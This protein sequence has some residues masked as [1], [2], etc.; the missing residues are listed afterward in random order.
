MNNCSIFSCVKGYI[1]CM[2][3]VIRLFFNDVA[4]VPTAD[5]KL[6]NAIMAI[7]FFNICHKIGKLPISTIGLGFKVRFF[8]NSCPKPSS[9]YDCLHSRILMF[10]VL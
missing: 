8:A 4:L 5:D 10:Y 3:E 6:I 7:Y 1:T 9:K 2:E